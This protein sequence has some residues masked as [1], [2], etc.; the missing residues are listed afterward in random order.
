MLN[1]ILL[2]VVFVFLMAGTSFGLHPLVTEDTGVQGRGNA[3]LEFSMEYARE[4]EDGQAQTAS[5]ATMTI[6]YGLTNNMDLIVGIPYQ[7][8]RTKTEEE[9]SS[10]DGMADMVMELKWKFYEKDGLSFALKPSVTLPSGSKRKGLG[11]GRAAYGLYFI[12]TKE[13]EPVTVHFNAMYKR[14]ENSREPK[15]RVDLWHISLASEIALAKQIRL[16]TNIGMDKNSSA[17]SNVNPA[18]A[19]GGLVYSFSKD[20][21]IDIGY[22]HGLNKSAT[23]YSILAGLTWRF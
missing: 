23:D 21:D 2:A 10:E 5:S 9:T 4:A 8:I 14:N 1:R 3:E 20:L 6:A 17:T 19:L 18:F 22:K 11:S 15:D 12:T 16:V 13:M 7:N